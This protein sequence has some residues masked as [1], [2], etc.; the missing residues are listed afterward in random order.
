MRDSQC[1]KAWHHHAIPLCTLFLVL[2]EPV[3]DVL[4]FIKEDMSLSAWVFV[5]VIGMECLEYRQSWVL[6]AS[7]NTS[8]HVPAEI[9]GPPTYNMIDLKQHKPKQLLAPW[10]RVILLLHE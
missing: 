4:Y 7:I 8:F 5:G 10:C 6:K 1:Q 2:T 3:K 9:Y